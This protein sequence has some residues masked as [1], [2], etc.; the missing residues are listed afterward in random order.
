MLHF[1]DRHWLRW[2][3]PAALVIGLWSGSALGTAVYDVG[4]WLRAW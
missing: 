3:S 1:I 4:H 2:A